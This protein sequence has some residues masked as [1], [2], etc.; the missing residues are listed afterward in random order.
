[1]HLAAQAGKAQTIRTYVLL[2]GREAQHDDAQC[3]VCWPLR[4]QENQSSASNTIP[5]TNTSIMYYEVII[6]I[7]NTI[8][9]L[10]A[11]VNRAYSSQST[12]L[13]RQTLFR[14]VFV[15]HFAFPLTFRILQQ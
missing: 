2:F 14:P 9:S 1:M 13:T 3:T 11:R 7:R 12:Y 4:K 15:R 6:N 10:T 8:A 5:T